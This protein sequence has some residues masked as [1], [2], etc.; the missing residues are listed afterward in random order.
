MGYR[1]IV[2]GDVVLLAA[3]VTLPE[4][5]EVDVTPLGEPLPGKPGRVSTRVGL[6]CA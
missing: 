2:Q 6:R 4:G 1:G 3:G 5:T